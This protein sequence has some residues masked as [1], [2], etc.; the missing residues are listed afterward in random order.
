MISV[1]IVA[2]YHT[3]GIAILY[4]ILSLSQNCDVQTKLQE[5]IDKT[6]EG[7]LPTL[8]GMNKL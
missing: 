4:T 1:F 2:G 7:H 8:D 3:T 5:E 6:L